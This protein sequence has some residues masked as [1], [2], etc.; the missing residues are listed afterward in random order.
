MVFKKLKF[1]SHSV[2]QLS[3]LYTPFRSAPISKKCQFNNIDKSSY[4]IACTNPR[5]ILREME[6]D[7]NEGA[8]MVMVK[9]GIVSLT[10]SA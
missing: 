10:L 7:I 9:P 5:Q 6:A 8:D 3:A 2:K 4:Q 1:L